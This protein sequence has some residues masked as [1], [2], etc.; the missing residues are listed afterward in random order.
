MAEIE[1]DLGPIDVLANNAGYGH[2]GTIEELS[3]ADLWRQFEINVFGAAAIG[4]SRSQSI[5]L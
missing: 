2:E 4:L 5:G 3:L 1:R